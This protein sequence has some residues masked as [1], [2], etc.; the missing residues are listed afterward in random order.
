MGLGIYFRD[1]QDA[2]AQTE[3][4]EASWDLYSSRLY[5]ATEKALAD[6]PQQLLD[7]INLLLMAGDMSFDMYSEIL[8]YMNAQPQGFEWAR[9]AMVYDALY[10]VSVSPEFAVQ[11]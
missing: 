10:L 9:Q 11:R 1:A 7:R 6:T 3:F 4:A 8:D 2:S 5:L